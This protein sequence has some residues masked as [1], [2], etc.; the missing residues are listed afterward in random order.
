MPSLIS[1]AATRARPVS[2]SA[3]HL[4]IHDAGAPADFQR[5][6]RVLGRSRRIA[7]RD[8]RDLALEEREPA[9]LL[10]VV[11]VTEQPV[12]MAEPALRDGVVAAEHDGVVGEPGGGAGGR[13]RIAAGPI[14]AERSRTGVQAR[15][16]VAE[17]AR[18]LGPALQRLG[19]LAVR[20]ASKAA[21]AS[22]HAPR[23]SA[24]KPAAR[25]CGRVAAREPRSRRSSSDG[26]WLRIRPCSSRSSSDGSRPRSSSQR[27][28]E[29]VVDRERVGVAA[30]PVE[31]EHRLPAQA[32]AQR[33]PGDLGRQLADQLCVTA[34]H[35]VRLD[36]VL[37]A[38]QPQ[39]VEAVALELREGLGELGERLAAPER[40]R[41]AQ[42]LRGGRPPRP[43]RAPRGPS[44]AAD[45][46]GRRRSPPDRPR[47]DSRAGGSRAPHPGAPC[48]A[49]R[50]R[51][52][53]SSSAVSGAASPHRSSTRR[54][55]ATVRLGETS[56]RASSAR[57]LSP[58]RAT[59]C[60]AVE[61]FHRAEQAELHSPARRY[62]RPM[63]ASS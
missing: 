11:R 24:S 12:G 25:L 49:A 63:A 54:S 35:Q 4:Q 41:L 50:R 10:A 13:A 39:L 48:A 1:P 51:S 26:S 27:A 15:V 61:H 29:V 52:G 55:T 56:R 32:L 53:P 21:L 7:V 17:E 20:E 62:Q 57:C 18:G 44:G 30:G 3:E 22:S 37:E 28:A 33:K 16:A 5:A 43:H 42:P 58:P 6:G 59:R 46:S 23:P 8:Q 9:A 47:R 34:R 14:G 2:E 60:L 40:Q 45:R 19:L 31:R 38:R 36:A